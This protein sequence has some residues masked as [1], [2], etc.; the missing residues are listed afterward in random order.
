[1][2][3]TA[4]QE[5]N[6]TEVKKPNVKEIYNE[7]FVGN[8]TRKELEVLR[9]T[10]ARGT[11]DEE[12]GLF[13]QTCVNSGLNPFLNHIHCTVYNAQSPNRQIS[14]QISS[15]GIMYLARK[16]EGFRG[17]DVQMVHENDEFQFDMST[18]K[19]VK[20]LIGFP[21]GQI[22]GAYA[23]ARH[24]DYEDKI[25]LMDVAEVDHLRKTKQ[26]WKLWF[27]DMFK[28]HILK[29]IAKEQYGIDVTESEIEATP[30]DNLENYKHE[31]GVIEINE[32]VMVK[33]EDQLKELWK[34]LEAN[35]PEVII[36]NSMKKY[37]KG[38]EDKDLNLQELAALK[39]FCLLEMKNA[40]RQQE[41][42]QQETI[43][44]EI[45]EEQIYVPNNEFSGFFD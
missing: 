42:T 43:E 1:M 13:V 18:K 7:K 39:K 4:I 5:V 35:V 27:A 38:K 31:P 26:M 11:N 19:V 9:N 14:I 32:G 24:K 44:A 3:N 20:H 29:R 25:L 15:E 30:I 34:E 23:I 40:D 28:K 17:V 22:I 37:F 10:I 33:E 21:R 41:H 12:F 6:P 2:T 45:V 8:F 36:L 16:Q